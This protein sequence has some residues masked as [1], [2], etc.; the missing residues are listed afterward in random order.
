MRLRYLAA[1]PLVAAAMFGT[2]AAAWPSSTAA[3]PQAP[4]ALAASALSARYAADAQAIA[5]AERTAAR[6]SDSQLAGAL[7]SLRTQHV[8]FFN[9]S[10]HG[11]A[12]MVI[13]NL[14]TATRV[15]ILVPGS[16]TTLATF[17]S[18]GSSSPGGG[19]E[20]LAAEAHRLEPFSPGERLAI[21]AWLGYPTPAT[22]SPAVM[23]SGDASQGAQALRPLVTALAQHGDQVAL[24]C[25]SYGSV[26]C[27]LAAPS[28]PVTDIAVFGSPGMDASSVATLHTKARVWAGQ[29][30]GDPIKYVPHIRLF[31][32]GF[33][34]D[35]MSPGFG[36]RIFA[37]GTGGHSGYLDPGSVSLRNLT[38][39]ALGDSAAVTR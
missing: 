20:A 6:D 9:P 30:S 1:G 33:V 26:V 7:A 12:A 24:L 5:G 4:P 31:G 2:T 11:V 32:L 13:G 38:Y 25:H 39:I 15:A 8:L 22:L 36:A 18:R 34:A 29:E 17:F 16:D 27:G 10:G 28:L 21:I 19:A 23:T 3:M 14:A 35:P 37:T